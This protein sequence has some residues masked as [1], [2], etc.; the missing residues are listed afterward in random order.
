MPIRGIGPD[1]VPPSRP[2]D[3]KFEIAAGSGGPLVLRLIA[4]AR[5]IPNHDATCPSDVVPV[6]LFHVAP[7][8]AGF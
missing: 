8:W 4:E 6:R 1:I 3:N 2:G 7:V 5:P